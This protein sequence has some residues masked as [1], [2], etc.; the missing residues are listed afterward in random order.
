MKHQ[1]LQLTS[2]K[3]E[4]EKESL[5][6]GA[7]EIVRWYKTVKR[8]LPWRKDR[9]PYR[10][11]ISEVMLQ[12]TTVVA[13]IPFYEKFL[14]RFPS[15]SELA[16]ASIED[17]TA[18]W[19]GLGYYSRARNLHKAA[20]LLRERGAFPKKY[21]DLIEF[22]G[23]GPYTARAVASLAFGQSV[24]VLDGN[25]IRVLSRR[26]GIHS[27][28]WQPKAR[29]NL[30]EIA[31][32]LAQAADSADVNQGLME[33]GATVC[34]PHRP[35]CLLCP[36]TKVCVAR[37]KDMIDEL[38]RKRPR[39][40]REIW[41]WKPIVIEDKGRVALIE[42]TYAPFLKKHWICPGQAT[43][44]A[45]PPKSYDY[46]H[47]V[48]HHDI[49]VVLAKAK[50]AALAKQENVQWVARHELKKHV[51]TTLVRRAIEST[52]KLLMIGLATTLLAVVSGCSSAPKAY[53]PIPVGQRP[54]PIAVAPAA[55]GAKTTT[56]SLVAEPLTT[57]G[58]NLR[59]IFS[60]DGK[61]I[62]FISQ[63]RETHA[64]A[65]VYEIDLTTRAEHRITF[66]DGD[67]LNAT[68]FPDGQ[69]I[70]Y[71]SA[72]DEIKEDPHFIRNLKKK[73]ETVTDTNGPGSTQDAGQNS[74]QDR[75]QTS[76][77]DVRSAD[78]LESRDSGHFEL[79]QSRLDGSEIRRLTNSPGLDAY[80]SLRPDGRFIAFSSERGGK[81]DLYLMS[82]AGQD[83]RR[84]K[85]D[86]A[87]EFDPKFSPDGR[88]LA[89]S[90]VGDEIGRAQ[91]YLGDGRALTATP[92]TS[93]PA[94]QTHPAWHPNG[95]ELAFASNRADNKTFDIYMVDR[96]GGCLKRLTESENDEL[97]PAF[98]PDGRKLAFS[99][100]HSGRW[101]I[102]VMD[103]SPPQNCMAETP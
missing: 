43:R 73:Y 16:D 90:Q 8:T 87:R 21:E 34:T 82:P 71:S 89:W 40:E 17:V 35:A 54:E 19:A 51:P 26:F 98:S 30:Q 9:D 91:I 85:S 47:S 4:K 31:D 64:H 59:P 75:N 22:P 81:R 83:I 61:R 101:Q 96:K 18:H 13:V 76:S 23:F 74:P 77:L 97:F 3:T 2:E 1:R 72:T 58:D 92:L 46:R 48:T 14:E 45:T 41:I 100:N 67:D 12:Q 60:P 56:P 70:L 57:L 7:V 63:S 49:F 29:H 44:V 52:S 99:S 80:A 103:V 38:P 62:L 102:Y 24:G 69:R 6:T 27:D 37:A 65:Q 79:Y 55:K 36:W 20:Q 5:V 42:N 32:H 93:K 68:Y 33:L 39:R 53:S 25:V 78:S 88:L 10:I 86:P 15:L 95:L 94:I 66:H 11:W 28:W 50:K 84:I